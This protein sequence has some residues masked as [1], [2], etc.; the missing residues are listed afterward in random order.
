MGSRSNE[1]AQ[2]PDTLHAAPAS[3]VAA[4]RDTAAMS[5]CSDIYIC[6]PVAR[7]R[8]CLFCC[9]SLGLLVGLAVCC[10]F[11]S[12]GR[13]GHDRRP[14]PEPDCGPPLGYAEDRSI[15]FARLTGAAYCDE[16]SLKAWNCGENCIEG[17][18]LPVLVCRGDTTQAYVGR[19]RGRAAV[20]FEGTHT[21]GS[22][23]RDL[24]TF[25]QVT[26]W[27]PCG[28]CGVHSGFLKE[29]D[30]LES[31]VQQS[32]HGV[33]SPQGSYVAIAGHSLGGA[34][35][36]LAI[37]QLVEAGWRLGEAYT[38][39]MPRLGSARFAATFAAAFGQRFHRVTHHMDP[40]P[41]VPPAA[42][43]FL[44][45]GLETFYDGNVSD[46]YRKCVGFEDY[47][48]AA[49]YWNL[50]RDILNA[51][52]HLDYM[53]VPTTSTGCRT[54]SFFSRVGNN[55]AAGKSLPD[56]PPSNALVV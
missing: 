42:F 20:I 51:G 49:Q 33:G 10:I 36:S 48:C 6:R 40:V 34:V 21:P 11:W 2:T 35:A 28:N 39:G 53:D 31:C 14:A 18:S 8:R 12:R 38:F 24:D 41:H 5:R 4:E 13:K 52:D 44:H 23:I 17:M 27:P 26:A 43:G 19:F 54:P 55:T 1:P 30:S 25:R 3:A 47:S 16:E 45:V 22:M 56:R 37:V 50:P 9:S 29:W 32:L 15:D 46:G 7:W